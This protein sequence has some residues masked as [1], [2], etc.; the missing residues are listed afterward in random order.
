MEAA[1]F[2]CYTVTCESPDCEAQVVEYS[3]ISKDELL[4]NPSARAEQTVGAGLNLE[5][6]D[7]W[8]YPYSH[9][10]QFLDLAQYLVLIWHEP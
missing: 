8:Y 6:L 10:G 1:V 2:A 9:H 4:L 5:Q 3:K 7:F